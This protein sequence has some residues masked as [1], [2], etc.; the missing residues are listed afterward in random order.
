MHNVELR[1][2]NIAN[3]GCSPEEWAAR[4]DLACA[5]RLFHH[6]GWHALIF[7]HITL[8]VPGPDRHFL[9]NPF[10][11]MYREVTASNLLKV[12]LDGNLVEPS[13]WPLFEAGF[14]VHSGIHRHNDHIHC[15]MHTH[16][17]TGVAVSCLAD[18]LLPLD[19]T[20][21]RFAGR[22][23]YH[24]FT[25]LPTERSESDLIAASLGDKE[26][27]IL[28]NH[29]LV[30][31]GHTLARAFEN[32]F[33]LEMACRAQITAQ[34]A[35]ARLLLQSKETLEIVTRQKETHPA[36]DNSEALW[37]AM[38]RWMRDIDPSFEA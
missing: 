27:M 9:I 7:N 35:G 34:S 6:L 15:V 31:C 30:A 14:V 21:L 4:V 38:L 26:V 25:M 13:P 19:S 22:I 10:G 2:R 32:L 28:R 33:L 8:R 29:G 17:D 11:L 24:D 36:E 23:A 16:S 12:D 5:Y 37:A 3:V 18:G 20:A 1:E